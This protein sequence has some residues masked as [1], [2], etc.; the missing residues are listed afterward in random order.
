MHSNP[1]DRFKFSEWGLLGS[2]MNRFEPIASRK[3]EEH[4]VEILDCCFSF[5]KFVHGQDRR[6]E[7]GV[8]LYRL[9]VEVSG[10]G[11]ANPDEKLFRKAAR[12]LH[13]S[14]IQGGGVE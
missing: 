11:Q 4:S 10:Y 14:T 5:Q 6:R 9:I 12:A 2:D 13:K 8:P 3:K 7:R 1:I